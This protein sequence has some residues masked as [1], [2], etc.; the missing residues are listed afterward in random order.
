MISRTKSWSHCTLW[1]TPSS[2]RYRGCPLQSPDWRRGRKVVVESA[3]RR[4]PVRRPRNTTL[5]LRLPQGNSLFLTLHSDGVQRS[6]DEGRNYNFTICFL[7]IIYMFYCHLGRRNHWVDQ[8]VLSR[9]ISMP[10]LVVLFV[11]RLAS[12]AHRLNSAVFIKKM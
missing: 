6:G 10:R 8:P 12:S 5:A 11:T 9:H 3:P 7:W 2:G 4:S 1:E